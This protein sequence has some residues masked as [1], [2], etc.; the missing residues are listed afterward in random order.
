[1]ARH[2][3]VALQ[4]RTSP[5]GLAVSRPGRLSQKILSFFFEIL[6]FIY[7]APKTDHFDIDDFDGVINGI[8]DPDVAN[9]KAVTALQFTAKRFDVVVIERVFR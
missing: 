3:P 6:P 8:D 1:M 5:P 4:R 7:V 2:R 9:P